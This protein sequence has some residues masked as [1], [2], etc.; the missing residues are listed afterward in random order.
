MERR[1]HLDALA[2]IVLL[3]LC[4]SWGV[5]QVVIKITVADVSPVMQAAIRSI[6]STILIALW[7]VSRSQR[8][9]ERD[10]TLRWG[11]AAGLLFA[12]EFLLIYWGLE[13][14]NA[15]RAIIFVYLSPFVVA[16]GSQ[17]FVPGERLP[18]ARDAFV[19]SRP[20]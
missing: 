8:I 4:M 20:Q 17:W 7:M 11:I 10:G 14:T 18:P 6:G 2:V 15:S 5:Q 16:I 1:N 3:V 13:F 9:F 19:N 12:I